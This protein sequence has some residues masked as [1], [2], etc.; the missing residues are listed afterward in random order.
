MS[1][2]VG[3]VIA[4]LVTTFDGITG[5]ALP[6]TATAADAVV[7][8]GPLPTESRPFRFVLVGSTGEDDDDFTTD[9]E[10]S[11][12]GPGNWHE[13]TGSVAC[14]AWAWSGSGDIAA[15]RAQALDLYEACR[16]AV[17]AN[18]TLG[19]VLPV[20][21]LAQVTA[22]RGRQVQTSNGPLCRVVFTVTYRT[23]QTS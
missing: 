2:A 16:D 14:S 8:D 7:F 13:E 19:G 10:V 4:A 18:R 21:G 23:V 11:A 15:L 17:A 22:G 6:A 1:V 20:N 12:M 9:D 3:D 5:F